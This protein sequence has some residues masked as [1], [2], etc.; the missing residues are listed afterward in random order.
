MPQ[1]D[2]A[3][4]LA[5]MSTALGTFDRGSNRLVAGATDDLA[6]RTFSS[7]LFAVATSGELT[8]ASMS[9]A[10]RG[11]DILGITREAVTET[12]TDIMSSTT[13]IPN[14]FV[15]GITGPALNTFFQ[16]TCNTAT[17]MVQQKINQK[18][19]AY[20]FPSKSVDVPLACDPTV[21][22]NVASVN[23]SGNLGCDVTLQP[24]QDKL[25]VNVALPPVAVNASA[26]GYCIDEVD[27]GIFGSL[28]LSEVIVD[29]SATI[30]LSNMKVS[31]AVPE[32]LLKAGG[33]VT[34]SFTPGTVTVQNT[35]GGVDV[36]CLSGVLYDIG[37]FFSELFG[38]PDL[39]PSFEG[40]FKEVDL[41][42]KIG[43]KEFQVA[44]NQVTMNK[45]E[46]A[47]KDK[48]LSVDLDTV[49]V[50]PGGLQMSLKAS[51]SSTSTDPEVEA[52]PGA[53]LTPAPAPVPGGAYT[54]VGNTF[55]VVA[56]DSFNQLFASMTTQGE[57]HTVC[58]PA[59][60]T[61]AE[62]APDDCTTLGNPITRGACQA[63]KGTVCSTLPLGERPS[64]NLVRNKM[65]QSNIGPN[66]SFLFCARLDVPPQILIQDDPGTAGVETHLR[67]NDLLASV[68]LDRNANGM[69]D[70]EL[71]SLRSASW[72]DTT[73]RPT[74]VCSAPAST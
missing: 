27:L 35:G 40:V 17:A 16:A 72:Q 6:N 3:A 61:I 19:A 41:T 66:M 71:P 33:D 74:A 62:L 39:T 13:E 8:A 26:H 73:P 14:A 11:P 50:Q 53:L 43:V 51:F 15:L 34:G 68:V 24:A 18:L 48:K 52:T 20:Q 9:M 38:G 64:C 42:E 25:T 49:D 10:P 45:Q 4:D 36:N 21:Y 32:T 47:D 30:T 55:F 67:L 60:Q 5:G 7:R 28:C 1:T 22:T 69:L 23:I 44:I 65:T 37:S 2:L 63:L 54:D 31:F 59:G 29:G 46:V 70:G 58:H 56:D 57:F 12:L